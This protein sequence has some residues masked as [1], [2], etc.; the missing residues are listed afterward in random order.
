MQ[1]KIVVSVVLVVLFLA[2]GAGVMFALVKSRRPPERVA[3]QLPALLVETVDLAPESVVE[4]ISG[5]GT[6]RADR[7]ARVSAQVSGQIVE[8]AD[9]LEAGVRYSAGD[10]LLRLDDRDYHEMLAQAEA[11]LAAERAQ[12]AQLE[13]EEG[14][15]A[16]LVAI[17]Q[18]QFDIQKAEYE[19]VKALREQD[20][21]HIREFDQQRQQLMVLEAQLRR[22]QNDQALLPNRREMLEASIQRLEAQVEVARLNVDRCTV[23]APFGGEVD[24]VMIEL[25]ERV[26]VGAPLLTLLDPATLEVPIELPV[27]YRPKVRVGVACRL[28][29]ESAPE[30]CWEGQVLRIDPRADELTRTFELYVEVD[31]RLRASP[32]MPGSFVQAEIDGPVLENVLIVPR[33]AVQQEQVFVYREGR[34]VRREVDVRQHLADRSVVT[35]LEPGDRVIVSNLDALYD[36][37]PIRVDPPTVS[38]VPETRPS[39]TAMLSGP[40]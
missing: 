18:E 27:S 10:M 17:V 29:M 32:L 16:R 33:G 25:G 5:Y 36:G 14:N 11:A 12:R 4:T 37:A 28:S 15:L 13:V 34:A 23:R 21:A 40:T 1:R 6:V 9:G 30:W 8:L 35:G 22:L 31:N 24:E 20:L 19:R 7:L 2:M 26:Q 39:P 3:V 38:E